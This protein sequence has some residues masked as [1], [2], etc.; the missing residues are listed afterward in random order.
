MY[1]VTLAAE[2]LAQIQSKIRVRDR[3]T[4]AVYTGAG[5]A[6][7]NGDAG[8]PLV[9]LLSEGTSGPGDAAGSARELRSTALWHVTTRWARW[10]GASLSHR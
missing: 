10:T 7:Q 8:P 4:K 6:A 2:D 1:I 9:L 5:S 3:M